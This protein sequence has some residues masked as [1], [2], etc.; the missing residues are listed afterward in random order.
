MARFF[1]SDV[2]SRIVRALDPPPAIWLVGTADERPVGT[3]IVNAC[4]SQ[5][6]SNLMGSTTPLVMIDMI[7]HSDLMLTNDTGP[8]HLAAALNIPTVALFGPTDPERT[9]P[10]GA[11]HKVFR[12]EVPCAPCFQRICPLE[13]QLCLNDVIDADAVSNYIATRIQSKIQ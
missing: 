9:G 3:S 6:V 2:I 1:F 8:M 11:Q 13:R 7:R 5:K 10:Y 4:Q 12:T